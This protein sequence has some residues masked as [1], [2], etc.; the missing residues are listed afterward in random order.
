MFGVSGGRGF[1]WG[2]VPGAFPGWKSGTG[3]VLGMV[4]G[5]VFWGPGPFSG[6]HT[7]N[8][9]LGTRGFGGCGLSQ[10]CLMLGGFDVWCFGGRF[11]V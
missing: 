11:G 8:P 10:R 9:K 2:V 1:L 6:A 4:W 3:R 5:A 7:S